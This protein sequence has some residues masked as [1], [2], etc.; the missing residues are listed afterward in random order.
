MF[1][2]LKDLREFEFTEGCFAFGDAHHLTL[3]NYDISEQYILD[4]LKNKN[5][6]NIDLIQI[7]PTIEDCFMALM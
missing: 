2:L 7:K 6:Q 4:F 5:H 1:R 3:K